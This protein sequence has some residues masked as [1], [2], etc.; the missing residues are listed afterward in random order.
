MLEELYR[1]MIT[2]RCWPAGE[3]MAIYIPCSHSLVTH[4][5]GNLFML[6]VRS[7]DIF[8]GQ[9]SVIAKSEASVGILYEESMCQQ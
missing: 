4:V 1:H 6:I 9:L 5:A 3:N 7:L 2:T 8:K